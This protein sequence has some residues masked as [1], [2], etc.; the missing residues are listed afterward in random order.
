MVQAGKYL[1][2]IVAYGVGESSSGK[3]RIEIKF[4]FKDAQGV[5]QTLWWNGYLTEKSIQ[6]TAKALVNCGLKGTDYD[7]LA[8]GAES[9]ML[10]MEAPVE[11]EVQNEEFEGKT[12][13]KIAWV[14]RP[15]GAK[16]MEPGLAAQK[17]KGLNLGGAV[18]AA[19]AETG[20]K[21]PP[22]KED[23]LGF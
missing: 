4:G 8:K 11:V 3:P 10:N 5:D 20:I 23:D 21:A 9:G 2:K 15:G 18:A 22:V 16:F 12:R 14:N 17:L 6:I 1:A 7:E 13:S 19:R